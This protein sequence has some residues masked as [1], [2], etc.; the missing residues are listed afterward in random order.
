MPLSVR[1]LNRATRRQY[2]RVPTGRLL[3]VKGK[4]SCQ[5]LIRAPRNARAA[6]FF[7]QRGGIH[8][9]RLA[10]GRMSSGE[11]GFVSGNEPPKVVRI[12][13]IGGSV[14]TD[15]LVGALGLPFVIV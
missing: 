4:S 2:A 9:A 6:L 11:P 12:R 14:P 3:I 7:T 5:W 8:R 1:L 10:A 15:K 13:M